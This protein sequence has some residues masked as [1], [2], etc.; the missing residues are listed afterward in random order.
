MKMINK[1]NIE[2][3]DSKS[4][5]QNTHHGDNQSDERQESI[6]VDFIKD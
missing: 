6:K 1:K 5:L 2:D 3:V 4:S